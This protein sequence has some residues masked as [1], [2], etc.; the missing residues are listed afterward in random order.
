MKLLQL[1]FIF[2]LLPLTTLARVPESELIPLDNRRVIDLSSTLQSHEIAQLTALSEEIELKSGAQYVIVL[3]ES[4]S[5]YTIEDYTFSLGE[6]WGLGTEKADNGIIMMIAL[7]DRKMRIEVGYGLEGAIPDALAKRI[8]ETQLKPNFKNGNFYEG[9]ITGSTTIKELIFKEPVSDENF[10][11][12]ELTT[13]NFSLWAKL[14]PFL[15][16]LLIFLRIT[17]GYLKGLGISILIL[18]AIVTFFSSIQFAIIYN[19]LLTVFTLIFGSAKGGGG[20]GGHYHGGYSGG[21]S[22][23]SSSGGFSGGGGS[24]GG[25]GA[26]GSW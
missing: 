2:L 14:F 9:I 24:F 19:L 5:P 4:T 20:N 1:I 11:K 12:Q 18:I 8:I 23:G 21:F 13:S 3:V 25:G 22:G 6:F 15:M 17:F 7:S 16:F 10:K 26:S